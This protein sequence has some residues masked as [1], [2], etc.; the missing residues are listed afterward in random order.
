MSRVVRSGLADQ[1]L[2]EIWSYIEHDNLRAAD[3]LIDELTSKFEMLARHKGLGTTR[4]KVDPSVLIFPVG[5]YLIV[6]RRIDDGIEVVRVVHSA[7]DLRKM[8]LR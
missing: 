2:Y 5:R 7:R 8:K 3:A 1:D 4:P 6:F